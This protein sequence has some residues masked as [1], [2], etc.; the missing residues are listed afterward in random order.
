M[1]LSK[2]SIV[3]VLTTKQE[4]N[5]TQKHKITNSMTIKLSLVKKTQNTHK[6]KL[7]LLTGPSSPVRSAHMSVHITE[8]NCGSTHYNTEQL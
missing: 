4:P 7:S 1:G 5:N 6:K 8:Y 2:Q 3:L